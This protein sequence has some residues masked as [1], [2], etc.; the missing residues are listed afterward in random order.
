MVDVVFGTH[1]HFERRYHLVARGTV[2]GSAEQSEI[3]SL[4]QYKVCFSIQGRADLAEP[5]ITAAALEAI[6]VPEQVQGF[7]QESL[8]DTFPATRA[9]LGHPSAADEIRGGRDR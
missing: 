1:H 8:G 4:T 2:P 7:Q 6:L 9:V 5:A 3:V